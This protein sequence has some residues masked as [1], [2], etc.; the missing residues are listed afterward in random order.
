M[1]AALDV[2]HRGLPDNVFAFA[3]RKNAHVTR[4][5]MNVLSRRV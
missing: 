3:S 5:A 4:V 1:H 2:R